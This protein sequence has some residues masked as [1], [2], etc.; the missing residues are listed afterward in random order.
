VADAAGAPASLSMLEAVPGAGRA[1]LVVDSDGQDHP[2]T[3]ADAAT[4]LVGA[5]LDEVDTRLAA[6][7]AAAGPGLHAYLAGERRDI[8]RWR[9]VLVGAGVPAEQISAKA[10]WSRGTANAPHGE[11]ARQG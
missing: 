2:P 6:E 11:P 3:A 9:D 5:D 1:L 7:V 10:Y 4:W 8:A